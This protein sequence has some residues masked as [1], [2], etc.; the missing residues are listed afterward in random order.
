M[1]WLAS[2]FVAILTAVAGAFAAGAVAALCVDWYHVSSREGASGYFVISIAFLGI[3][4]GAILGLVSARIVAA[5]AHPSFLRALGIALGVTIGLGLVSGGIARLLADVPPTIGGE[6][7]LLTLE[8]RFPAD[9]R[10]SP[11]A[12]PDAGYLELHSVPMFSH[13]VRASE[14]GALW[15]ED[16]RQVDGR[17]V[18]PGAVSV[19]TSRGSRTVSVHLAGDSVQGF[20]ISLPAYPGRK[21]LEWSDWYP[22]E[23]RGGPP[24]ATG[25][26][27]RF[28]V[29]PWTTPV[30]TQQIGRFAVQTIASSFYA[31]TI[32]SVTR[33]LAYA[34]FRVLFDGKP[35]LFVEDSTR[36][37]A[38]ADEVVLIPGPDPVLLVHLDPPSGSGSCHLLVAGA[39]GLSDQAIPECWG[40]GQ[41]QRLTSDNAQFHAAQEI[42]PLSGRIDD[43]TMPERGLYLVGTTVLDTRNLT[44]HPITPDSALTLIPAVPPLGVSPDGRSIIRYG[45]GAGDDG[46]GT[47]ERPRLGVTDF[48]ANRSYLVPIDP[49]RMRYARFEDIDPAWVAHH[50]AWE[51]GSDGTD[52]LVERKGFV[53]I[54]YQG[55]ISTDG[56]GNQ[57]YRI[58][59]AGAALRE[60]LIGF[61]VSA[62]KGER[63]PADSDAYEVPVKVEGGEVQV[64]ASSD[65]GYVA[66]SMASGSGDPKIVGAIGERFNAALATGRYDALFAPK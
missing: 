5:G 24:R 32:D 52:H 16:A 45:F 38:D 21:Q 59:K 62:F 25:L 41:A 12:P 28:R 50:F 29:Q 37:P 13:T 6:A 66:V 14:R 15:L 10:T 2:L 61:L 26:N 40:V 20:L 7:L 64:A 8:F 57:Y 46:I 18:V 3:I 39:T 27:Y 54:P 58:E 36:A 55:V 22:R 1:S 31:A 11:A 4:L 34:R 42:K 30:R 56:S 49:R 53:P 47:E 19:F 60:E 63:Q 9:Q 33:T 44:L 17:W 65:F 23:G 48:L 35:A 51:R 43:I